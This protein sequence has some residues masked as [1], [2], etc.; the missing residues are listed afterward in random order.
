MIVAGGIAVG[1]A[2]C[3][4]PFP[5]AFFLTLAVHISDGVLRPPWLLGGFVLAGVLA[6]L[7]AWRIRDEEIPRVALLTAAFFVASSLN[8]RVG[9]TSVHLLLNGLV[10]VVLG[11]RAALAIP[12]GLFLQAALVQHGG[13][14]TLGVNSCILVLPALLAWQLFALL[15]RVPWV[16]RP[17]FRSGLVGTSV[18]LWTLSLVYS[19]ALLFGNDGDQLHALDFEGANRLTFHPVALALALFVAW[20]AAW[21]ERRL[22]NAPEFP[23]GLLIGEAAVLATIALNCL[24]LVEGGIE[25]WHTLALALV[26]AH[27]PIA[28]VEGVVLGFTVGFLARVKPEMLGWEEDRAGPPEPAPE[29]TIAEKPECSLDPRT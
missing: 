13:F 19:L 10:G 24:V 14:S 12:V 9:P 27:L 3:F 15:R 6:F 22:D 21:L 18:L 23:L 4:F 5:F 1:Q 29:R 8:V 2:W 26:V 25:P 11:W 20:L 28:V 17:W 16:R 7:G